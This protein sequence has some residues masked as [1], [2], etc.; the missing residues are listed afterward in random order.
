VT[1]KNVRPECAGPRRAA[2]REGDAQQQAAA[3]P[4]KGYYVRIWKRDR[5]RGRWKLALDTTR[6][7]PPVEK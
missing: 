5:A 4:E 2:L 7:L 3:T 1:R 6:P